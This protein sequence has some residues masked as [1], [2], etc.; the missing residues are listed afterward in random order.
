MRI[1]QI[2]RNPSN[3]YTW[4]IEKIDRGWVRLVDTKGAIHVRTVS[5]IERLFEVY[6][7]VLVP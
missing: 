1:D 4:R 3:G 7:R 2:V 5:E 6:D